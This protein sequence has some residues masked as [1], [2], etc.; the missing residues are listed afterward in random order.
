MLL[1]PLPEHCHSTLL[2]ARTWQDWGMRNARKTAFHA[3][4]QFYCRQLGITCNQSPQP[5]LIQQTRPELEQRLRSED[6]EETTDLMST[7][8]GSS[9]HLPLAGGSSENLPATG[10][11]GG[12]SLAAPDSAAPGA[13]TTPTPVKAGA[14]GFVPPPEEQNQLRQRRMKSRKG[15]NRGMAEG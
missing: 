14:L 8:Q 1:V 10:M 2:H 4:A 7:V 13:T 5:V 9:D 12:N 6:Q 15:A 11:T 3:A